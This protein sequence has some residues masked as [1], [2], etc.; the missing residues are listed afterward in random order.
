VNKKTLDIGFCYWQTF[1]SGEIYAFFTL[2]NHLPG[3]PIN[4]LYRVIEYIAVSLLQGNIQ[5]S[6]GITVNYER[7]L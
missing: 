5:L 7:A 3:K 6:I 2:H 1:H 4:P